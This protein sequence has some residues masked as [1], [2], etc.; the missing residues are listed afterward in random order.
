M[1]IVTTIS[2][3]FARLRN[4][5]PFIALITVASLLG[6]SLG[7][8]VLVTILSV[9]NGFGDEL[10]GRLLAMTGHVVIKAVGPVDSD[11][12][13]EVIEQATS[14]EISMFVE[15]D[16]LLES[17]FGVHTAIVRGIDPERAETVTPL[18]AYLE[19]AA[20]AQLEEGGYKAVIGRELASALGLR[21][22]DSINV[23]NPTPR[24]TPFG[25]QVRSRRFELVD[26]FEFGIHEHDGSL[27]LVHLEDARRL[28]A[29]GPAYEGVRLRLALAADATRVKKA[30]QTGLTRA[31]LGESVDVLDWTDLNATLYRALAIEKLAMFAIFAIAVGI[32]GLNLVSTLV[33]NV[34]EQRPAI[35]SLMTMGLDRRRVALTFVLQGLWLGL[36]GTLLGLGLGAV[37]ANHIDS[38][39]AFAEDF[40]RFKLLS[41]EVYYISDIPS[42]PRVA[43][44]IVTGIFALLLSVLAP[45]YP[46]WLAARTQPAEIL[47][48]V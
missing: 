32:A 7:V 48:D 9:M 33:M 6:T 1:S 47:R 23:I 13:L 38:I 4:T 28:F 39:V 5:N 3:R 42:V 40:F 26:A 43:D 29:V 41:P 8:A 37:L 19:Y 18:A 46:A 45:L 22:G 15:R 16:A 17:E 30:L 34:N 11:R 20:L 21:V 36:W 25:P 10:R 35:A 14:A 2:W 44:F 24:A 31:A 27:L 12:L